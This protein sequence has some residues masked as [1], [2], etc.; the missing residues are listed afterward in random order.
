MPG[1]TEVADQDVRSLRTR[2]CRLRTQDGEPVA[3]LE[4]VSFRMRFGAVAVPVE[5]IG[6]VETEPRFRRQG[7]MSDLLRRALT[8]MAQ[9]VDVAFVSDGIEG[10][11]ERFGFAGAVAEGG[12]TVPVRN[13][14]SVTGADLEG[15]VPAGTVADL[16]AMI[17][18]YNTAHAQRPWTHERAPGWNRLVPQS[19]WKPGSRTLVL[20]TGGYAV[21]E[22]RAFGDPLGTVTVDEAVAEDA[23]AARH[24]LVALARLCWQRRLA[25]FTI[26]EPA[27]GLIGRVARRMGCTYRQS[28][29]PS[30]G[31]MAAIL[32]RAPLLD[33]L[34]PELR[35]RA[36]QS[37][38][39]AFAALRRGT[40]IPDDRTLI[41][42]LLGHWSLKDAYD[43]SI[44]APYQDICTAWFPGG[45]TPTLPA[46]YAHRLDRY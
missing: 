42:L 18:L 46:P 43:T 3:E 2:Y 23:A 40:L 33:R 1:Y 20:P 29:P 41:R 11:Y 34:E 21:L 5:G 22:G 19:T 9:R 39:E 36:G 7:H 35:R 13:V 37:H 30:G 17:R 32:N 15:D 45:G 25:E 16:P 27:D 31:M 44:P 38:D 10:V 6:G 4:A 24:L 12:L 26:R 14:E 28:T 8:G